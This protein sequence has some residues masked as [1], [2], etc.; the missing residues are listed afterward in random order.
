MT[1]PLHP[2]IAARKTAL[3][4]LSRLA[5]MNGL[6]S[7]QFVSDMGILVKR[8][9]LLDKENLGLIIVNDCF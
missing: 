4:F 1:L 3:S 8:I 6:T 9:A 2:K 5:E 7:S